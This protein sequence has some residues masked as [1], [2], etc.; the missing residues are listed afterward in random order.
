MGNNQRL[1]ELKMQDKSDNY[2][3]PKFLKAKKKK[4]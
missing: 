1:T 2:S 3:P 4:K